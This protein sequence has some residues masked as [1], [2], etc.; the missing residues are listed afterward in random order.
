MVTEPT[1]WCLTAFRATAGD[2]PASKPSMKSCPT[3]SSR[4]SPASVVSTQ[5]GG[6]GVGDGL[7]TDGDIDGS[8]AYGPG[9][10]P[11]GNG[12]SPPGVDG[13][14]QPVSQTATATSPTS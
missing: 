13:D 6:G 12:G 4:S 14:P 3:R 8:L 7:G 5:V 1:S 9:E 2:P 11:L 10:L